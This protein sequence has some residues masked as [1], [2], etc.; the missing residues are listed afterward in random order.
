MKHH[1]WYYFFLFL[2]FACGIVAISLVSYSK[3]LQMAL[4]VLLA[5]FYVVL[6]IFHHKNN[7]TITAK[8]VIEYIAIA[9]VAISLLVF[10]FQGI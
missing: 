10:V 3:S 1:H 2:I 6:G 8:I 5:I 7:H 9:A 4:F